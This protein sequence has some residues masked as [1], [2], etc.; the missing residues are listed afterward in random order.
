MPNYIADAR[1]NNIIPQSGSLTFL[2]KNPSKANM[3]DNI[4]AKSEQFKKAG[5]Q[6]TK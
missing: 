1:K 4:M 3:Y 5:D 2:T 6:F